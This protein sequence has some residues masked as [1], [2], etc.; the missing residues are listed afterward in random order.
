[1]LSISRKS[2]NVI[3]NLYWLRQS[4]NDGIPADCKG[5]YYQELNKLVAYSKRLINDIIK[6]APNG[7]SLPMDTDLIVNY[8]S[9][10]TISYQGFNGF[11]ETRDG[12]WELDEETGEITIFYDIATPLK[13][14]RFTKIHETMHFIQ[15]LD[16]GFQNY[17]DELLCNSTLPPEVV[18]KLFEKSTD[19]ATAMYLMPQDYFIKKFKEVKSISVLADEFQVSEQSASYRLKECGITITI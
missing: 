10:Y 5:I 6:T 12:Y 17:F 13:R 11:L 7:I 15:S 19:K 14:Q 16:V 3:D 4:Y 18:L 9:G 1:M 8:L 2:S